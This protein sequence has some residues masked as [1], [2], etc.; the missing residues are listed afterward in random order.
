MEKLKK[1]AIEAYNK[2]KEIAIVYV[3]EDGYSFY[4]ENAV[5]LHATTSGTKKIKTHKFTVD[6]LVVSNK[7]D[8]AKIS[9]EE[10]IKLIKEMKTTEEIDAFIEKETAKTVLQAAKSQKESLTKDSKT[11][12]K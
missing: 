5:K 10:R 12:N 1:I 3:S 8:E 11:E 4:S 9:A 2:N 6:Q 7:K